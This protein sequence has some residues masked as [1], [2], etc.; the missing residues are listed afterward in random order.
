MAMPRT[1][2]LA[3]VVLGW[4]VAAEPAEQKYAHNEKIP[5]YV[6]NVVPYHNPSESYRYYSLKFCA[7]PDLHYHYKSQTLGE[8]LQGSRKVYSPYVLPFAVNVAGKAGFLCEETLGQADVDAFRYAIKHMYYY[9]MYYDEIPLRGFIGEVDENGKY[10]LNTLHTFKFTFN[11]DR[12]IEAS[13]HYDPKHRVEV[14][15]NMDGME[16]KVKFTYSAQWTDTEVAFDDRAANNPNPLYAEELE[17]QWFSI[18]NSFVLV[19]LLTGFL[20]FIVMRILKKDYQ[21]YMA[22]DDEEDEDE[23]GW[24]LVHADVFRLPER[25][26]LFSAIMGTGLQ[27]LTVFLVMLTLAVVG[28]FYPYGRGTMYAA[29]IVIY[30]VTAVI[31]GYVSGYTYSAIGGSSSSE[32]VMSTVGLFPVPVFIIWSYLNSIAWGL[33]STA[34]LPFGTICALFAMYMLITFPL[35][36]AGAKIGITIAQPLEVPCRTNKVPRSIPPRPWYAHN[37]VHFLV[38]G[39]LPFSAIFVELYY[40]VISLW[41]HQ[42][43]TPF[44][45]LY[46]SFVILLGVTACIN[47]SLTYLQLSMENHEWW[48]LAIHSGGSTAFF[49]YAYC[50]YFMMVDSEMYGFMQLSF[51]FG[52][53]LITC[54]GVY[55]MLGAVGWTCSYIFVKQIFSGCK[56]D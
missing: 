42:Q 49:I 51:Y 32:C 40:I 7:P 55:I 29:I 4:E 33:G 22:M 41:G 45:I 46:L 25:K 6:D 47:V 5:L 26:A 39:F 50:F 13:V 11:R 21:R 44:G 17:I 24:K 38:A 19:V 27:L 20:A 23:T 28:V 34:A 43:Y 18:V 48:W 15:E 31:S 1:V 35:T 56:T 3:L 52:Y 54:Y 12:V 9:S 2:L 10:W 16:L 14:P 37:I 30:S 8:V 53:M 36:M